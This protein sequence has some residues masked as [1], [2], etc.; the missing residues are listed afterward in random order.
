MKFTKGKPAN[1]DVK[2]GVFANF[3]GK[4]I[5][6]GFSSICCVTQ[7]GQQDTWIVDTGASDHM[8]HNLTLFD[9]LD[10]LQQPVYVTFPDG[11][12]KN[13]TLWGN[14]RVD[15]NFI[16]KRVLYVP[17]FK[18]NLLSVTK[19]LADQ[20]LCIHV[21]PTQCI[22]QD[23]TNSNI[24]AAAHA[25]NGL[26]TLGTSSSRSIKGKG[27]PGKRIQKDTMEM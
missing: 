12:V 24:V 21:Y 25:H 7:H 18:F 26:Y 8:S 17:E 5:F 9:K 15:D 19:L 2:D 13:V 10:L 16:L 20:R 4:N 22:F 14:G 1:Y 23:L 11:S 3:A 6:T 27:F